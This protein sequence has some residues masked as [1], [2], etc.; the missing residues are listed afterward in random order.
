[1]IRICEHLNEESDS[2]FTWFTSVGTGPENISSSVNLLNED[3]LLAAGMFQRFVVGPHPENG[4]RP[5]GPFPGQ[6]GFRVGLVPP[7]M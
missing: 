3:C 1:M 7:S 5:N 6:I 2:W 4:D